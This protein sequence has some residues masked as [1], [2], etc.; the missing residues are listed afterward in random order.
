MP[1]PLSRRLALLLPCLM[2]APLLAGLSAPAPALAS[3]QLHTKSGCVACHMV[4]R[5]LV[6]PSYKEI[7][8]KY[9]GR[10]DA[11]P[12][13]SQR[14][15]KGGPGNWGTVPMAPNDVSKLNDAEL[16]ALLA[17]ILASA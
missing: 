4:D 7:A 10:A 15:R 13:L 11:I 6:G 16:K 17:W 3:N 1:T 12:F 2:A 8:V 9:K 14:V 5:K